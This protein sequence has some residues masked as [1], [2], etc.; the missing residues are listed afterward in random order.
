MNRVLLILIWLCG[1]LY[2]LS[3]YMA[4]ASPLALKACAAFQ[5]LMDLCILGQFVAYRRN[6]KVA[7][8]SAPRKGE[9][10]VGCSTPTVDLSQSM[11][12]TASD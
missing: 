9:V 12:S 5:I 7:E 1:D 3:Y 8:L 11:N 10:V 4:N 2:K 6:T